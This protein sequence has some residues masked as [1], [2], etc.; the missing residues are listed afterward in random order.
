MIH[1]QQRRQTLL[2]IA[3]TG[4]FLA[5]GRFGLDPAAGKRPVTPFAFPTVVPLS[6]WQLL[7]SRPLA[8]PTA[9]SEARDAFLASQK[10]RYQQNNQQLEIEMHYVVGTLGNLDGYFKDYISM[11]LKDTQLLRNLRQ[12]EGVGFY[13]LFVHQG[14]SHL[15]ACINPRGGSTV[16]PEQF[17]ANRYTYDLRLR[18]LATWLLGQESLRDKRCLWQHLSIPLNQAPAET[19]YPVLEQAWLASYQ[20]WSP[21]FPRH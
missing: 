13:S 5:L 20:W 11:P 19:T 18:R 3:F 14:R 15:S 17:T 6:G 1:W 4:V 12:Q 8:R 2:A 9:S 7:E 21:R 16:T 10:Y